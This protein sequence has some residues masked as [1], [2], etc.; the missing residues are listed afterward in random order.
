MSIITFSEE[1][2]FVLC[3]FFI[4]IWLPGKYNKNTFNG[5]KIQHAAVFYHCLNVSEFFVFHIIVVLPGH[6]FK[7]YFT[8]GRNQ[9]KYLQMPKI[10]EISSNAFFESYLVWCFS[11][12]FS[13]WNCREIWKNYFY[14]NPRDFRSKWLY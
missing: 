10:G 1:N 11:T 14:E 6:N 4:I 13:V 2:V 3:L 5:A 8:R 9:C 7:L 12:N